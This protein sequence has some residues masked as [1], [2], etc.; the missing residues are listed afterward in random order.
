[1]AFG[2]CACRVLGSHTHCTHVNVA[3]QHVVIRP[4][5]DHSNHGTWNKVCVCDGIMADASVKMC[6]SHGLCG[7]CF[8]SEREHRS[9]HA[10]SLQYV[11]HGA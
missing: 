8:H 9:H 3:S 11:Y 1:M 6:P 2:M 7:R 4:K 10:K 5:R